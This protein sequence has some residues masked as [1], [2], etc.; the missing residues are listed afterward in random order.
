[1]GLE[2][3]TPRSRITHSTDF[4][5]QEPWIVLIKK[6]KKKQKCLFILR[7][8]EH[9]SGEGQRERERKSESQAGSTL[10]V[11]NLMWGSIPQTSRS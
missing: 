5:S 6:K 7:E 3:T 9:V 1:M 4:A 11:Q 2:I 8:R 10:S